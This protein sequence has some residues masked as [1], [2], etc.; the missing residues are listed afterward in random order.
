[1]EH[2]KRTGAGHWRGCHTF[3]D[4][5]CDG[6][7]P[8]RSPGRSGGLKM[9]G[10]Y[11]YYVSYSFHRIL[12]IRRGSLTVQWQYRL[13]RDI[14]YYNDAEP[15]TS[16]C[17]LLPG[18]PVNILSVPIVLPDSNGL[19]SRDNST[20]SI[21]SDHRTMDPQDKYMN[22]RTPPKPRLPR[23]K[24][25]P[26]YQQAGPS[27]SML[28]LPTNG[29]EG[30]SI[31]Q[32]TSSTYSPLFRLAPKVKVAR[33]VSPPRSRGLRAAFLNFAG[34][35][36][37]SADR[38]EDDRSQDGSSLQ[39]P[40]PTSSSHYSS[41]M[42][43]P[44][45]SPV[46]GL[47]IGELPLRRPEWEKQ[48]GQLALPIR[49]RRA[50]R[51]GGRDRTPISSSHLALESR[52]GYL[53]TTPGRCLE[54]LEEA[55]SQQNTPMPPNRPLSAQSDA[56]TP[57][58]LATMEKRLPTLPNSPSSV[59]DEELRAISAQDQMLNMDYLHS[60][61][62]DS[63]SGVESD[64]FFESPVDK[65]RFSEWTT[66][67]EMISPA[68][69]TSSSTFNPDQSQVSSFSDPITWPAGANPSMALSS[70][71]TTPTLSSGPRMPS[72]TTFAADSP[73][74]RSSTA[75]SS[76]AHFPNSDLGI[77]ALCLEDFDDVIENNPKRHAGMFPSLETLTPLTLRGGDEP[78]RLHSSGAFHEK[79]P[80]V[81]NRR[82][83][84]YLAQSAAMKELMDELGYL[85]DII[86]AGL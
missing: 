74:L 59:M 13:D 53:R 7:S 8:S 3:T 28:N 11:W 67:T 10:M 61:F 68:S 55:L 72:S 78:S 54:T 22:P 19:H 51:S 66:D 41:R 31:S 40:T 17:P 26:P 84:G 52:N 63:T 85:G 27:W 70:G 60:H 69:M 86:Q 39:I 18:Q 48:E 58:P 9:G 49:V 47:R 75:N 79:Q 73:I 56:V 45:A 34:A 20:S 57:T 29:H 21:R 4:I 64:I 44:M 33:S 38:N 14:E 37:P 46:D 43:S 6:T 30:R 25:S 62:S 83:V 36:S 82:S 15:V 42:A 76:P 50:S 12:V 32:P 81:S 80:S 1:M 23:L 77:S 24:T 35:R 2:D 71:P 65:S 16:L 5:I